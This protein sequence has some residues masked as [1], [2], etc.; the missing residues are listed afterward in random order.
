MAQ[1]FRLV[2]VQVNLCYPNVEVKLKIKAGD[3][4]LADYFPCDL[5]EQNC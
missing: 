1:C 4:M 2:I 3:L 5:A